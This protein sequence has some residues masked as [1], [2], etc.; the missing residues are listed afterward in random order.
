M[1]GIFSSKDSMPELRMMASR[2][3]SESPVMECCDDDAALSDE[4]E[5]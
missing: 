2:Q 3:R 1:G 5:F 4:D